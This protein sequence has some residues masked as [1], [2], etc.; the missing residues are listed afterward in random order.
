MATA[1]SLCKFQRFILS[2]EE[3]KFAVQVSPY[4]LML[5]RNK[6]SHYAEAVIEKGLPY[7]SDPTKQVEAI[8]EFER[9]KAQVSVL[10]EL[11]AELL[12]AQ[13]EA[14]NLETQPTPN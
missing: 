10:E 3:M 7:S 5:L 2:E 8:V 12:D 13:Q 9:L 11:C 14:P 1:D 4:F 6:I